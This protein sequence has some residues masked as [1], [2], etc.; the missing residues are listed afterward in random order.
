M[1]VITPHSLR[2][3]QSP[4]AQIIMPLLVQKNIRKMFQIFKRCSLLIKVRKHTVD[5][6]IK[7]IPHHLCI[8][9]ESYLKSLINQII[10]AIWTFKKTYINGKTLENR[11]ALSTWWRCLHK[12][13]ALN[14]AKKRSLK[15]FVIGS[16]RV[17][18]WHLWWK[19]YRLAAHL[20]VWGCGEAHQNKWFKLSCAVQKHTQYDQNH[21]FVSKSY[22]ETLA[23][24]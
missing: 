11:L 2:L 18:A 16:K 4:C 21:N 15:C 8:R 9:H 17:T 1:Q 20:I 13:S 10:F 19:R 23:F 12:W 22:H 24:R 6:T 3:T 5:I 14:T 7:L